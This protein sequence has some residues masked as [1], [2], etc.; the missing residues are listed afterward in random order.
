MNDAMEAG[1]G[2]Y[3]SEDTL[4]ACT[5]TMQ[6][7]RERYKGSGTRAMSSIPISSKC[8]NSVP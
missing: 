6:K 1:A 8:W 5:E 2:I 3:R 4:K 7:I